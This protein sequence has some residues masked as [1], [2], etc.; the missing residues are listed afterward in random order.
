MI[1]LRAREWSTMESSSSVVIDDGVYD[2][3]A[4]TRSALRQPAVK[5]F[6][7]EHDSLSAVVDHVLATSTSKE[8]REQLQ[9][10]RLAS[11]HL[12][13]ASRLPNGHKWRAHLHA[14]APPGRTAERT[15]WVQ[16]MM[17]PIAHGGIGL[18]VDGMCTAPLPFTP[19]TTDAEW[20]LLL[21]Q[22]VRENRERRLLRAEQQESF[23]AH[24]GDYSEEH[25]RLLR[26]LPNK[27]LVDEVALED[28]VREVKDDQEEEWLEEE[29]CESDEECS[30]GE[31]DFSWI[32]FPEDQ[33][34]DDEGSEGDEDHGGGECDRAGGS[35]VWQCRPARLGDGSDDVGPL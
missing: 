17:E 9:W 7:A 13:D 22:T 28:E 35:G 32:V 30:D 33:S 4:P 1:Q 16:C 11:E 8:L 31:E 34:E 3:M 29:E 18:V 21:R 2:L 26:T 6:A 20:E 15:S 24:F 14:S 12:L 10:A 5:A 23:L 25:E 27:A 19:P